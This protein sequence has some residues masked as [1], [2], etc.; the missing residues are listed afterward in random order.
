MLPPGMIAGAQSPTGTAGVSSVIELA[1]G[2]RADA[3]DGRELA[4]F[5]AV[6]IFIFGSFLACKACRRYFRKYI[7]C[8]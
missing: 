3:D 7:L 2:S 1:R 8:R 6:E 5:D 4:I